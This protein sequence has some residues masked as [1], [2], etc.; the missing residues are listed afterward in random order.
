MCDQRHCVPALVVHGGAGPIPGR[1]VQEYLEGV[2]SALVLGWEQLCRGVPALDVAEAVVCA[3]EDAPVFDAGRGSFLNRDGELEMDAMLM[4]GTD[5]GIGA[6]AGVRTVRNPIRLARAIMQRTPHCFL[7][8]RGAEAFAQEAGIPLCDPRDLV[9]PEAVRLWQDDDRE[10]ASGKGTVGC[11]VRDRAGEIV[12]A[13]STGGMNR[14]LPGRVG[15]T[16]LPGCG[17]FAD[18]RVGGV[19]VTGEGEHLM[20]ITAARFACLQLEQGLSPQAAA[21]RTVREL[22]L[23]TGGQG[24]LIVMDAQGRVGAAFNTPRMAR[25]WV[26]SDGAARVMVEPGH[27]PDGLMLEDCCACSDS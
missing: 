15:D 7:I 23:R 21:E 17:G 12:A 19:S 27:D 18:V 5:L 10:V 6:C 2:R 4:A 13:T 14:K 11:V 25:G 1:Q 3:M 24:G 16:P 8:G 9:T 20:R 26:D 22:V